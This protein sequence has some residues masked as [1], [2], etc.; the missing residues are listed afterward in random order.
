MW[1]GKRKNSSN[2]SAQLQS[3]SCMD[4]GPKPS[5]CE[6]VDA[7]LRTPPFKGRKEIV[8]PEIEPCSAPP[9]LSEKLRDCKGHEIEDSSECD[10]TGSPVFQ[11]RAKQ[12]FQR[13]LFWLQHRFGSA[14]KRLPSP[15]K[16]DDKST[17]E[18]DSC[19]TMSR[20]SV[21]V[22]EIPV[23][24]ESGMLEKR[25]SQ[26]RNSGK[27]T[28]LQAAITPTSPSQS[29]DTELLKTSSSPLPSPSSRPPGKGGGALSREAILQAELYRARR[30][31]EEQRVK[32][33]K[34]PS[35][36]STHADLAEAP[37]R[38]WKKIQDLPRVL[39]SLT[40]ACEEAEPKP[41][42]L[43][44]ALVKAVARGLPDLL[45]VDEAR[46][47]IA[48][49]SREGGPSL[50]TLDKDGAGREV[51]PAGL[52]GE[53]VA[54][55][56][57]V[58][59]GGGRMVCVPVVKAREGKGRVGA[60]L[61]LNREEEDLG[62]LLGPRRVQAQLE[63]RE[64]VHS[65]IAQHI[66]LLLDGIDSKITLDRGRR[67][68]FGNLSRVV[69]RRKLIQALSRWVAVCSVSEDSD[70]PLESPR[71]MH[72][73]V[74][75]LSLT[76]ALSE[77]ET[78]FQTCDLRTFVGAGER[79]I[80]E[81]LTTA[82]ELEHGWEGDKQSS[83]PDVWII[84][85]NANPPPGSSTME[86]FPFS[87]TALSDPSGYAKS[88]ASG[89]LQLGKGVVCVALANRASMS[90]EVRNT[91]RTLVLAWA[92]W[93]S[94]LQAKAMEEEKAN[95]QELGLRVEEV[96]IDAQALKGE[97]LEAQERFC[98][99]RAQSNENILS[100]EQEIVS[101]NMP[102]A[103]L[104]ATERLLEST[105]DW[106]GLRQQLPVAASLLVGFDRLEYSMRIT[107]SEL[108]HSE[109]L[110]AA[111]VTSDHVVE[112]CSSTKARDSQVL[113]QVL[114]TGVPVKV[115]APHGD[116]LS[117]T[118]NTGRVSP[119]SSSALP[120]PSF[121]VASLAVPLRSVGSPENPIGALLIERSGATVSGF[122]DDDI[123]TI[124][125][126]AGI[127]SGV[128]A[129]LAL[130]ELL[131]QRRP[132]AAAGKHSSR[133]LQVAE[134]LWTSAGN[135][136]AEI[137]ETFEAGTVH[138]L[139][140]VYEDLGQAIDDVRCTV[141]MLDPQQGTLCGSNR[142]VVPVGVGA[143]GTVALTGR[144]MREG[145][146]V[147]YVPILQGK[148]GHDQAATEHY[149]GE[150][151]GAMQVLGVVRVYCASA[152][153]G[154]MEGEQDVKAVQALAQILVSVLQHAQTLQAAFGGM[155]DASAAIQ[156]L[157]TRL[158]AAQDEIFL[159][160]AART[161]AE[162]V[163]S[164]LQRLHAECASGG[165]EPSTALFQA[166]ETA[167]CTTTG[168]DSA[169]FLIVA[170]DEGDE[171]S[172]DKCAGYE[173]TSR[174][175]SAV[176]SGALWTLWPGEACPEERSH[177]RI[178]KDEAAA[179]IYTL[180]LGSSL[181]ICCSPL[182]E[183]PIDNIN[184]FSSSS[185]CSSS[186][187]SGFTA[188]QSWLFGQSKKFER[189]LGSRMSEEK[190]TIMTMPVPRFGD[191]SG[192]VGVLEFV[193]QGRLEGPEEGVL[194]LLAREVGIIWAWTRA[195]EEIS[196]QR[197]EFRELHNTLSDQ[198]NVLKMT[199]VSSQQGGMLANLAF[200]LMAVPDREGAVTAVK[201][202]IQKATMADTVE[203]F[204]Q[205]L[206]PYHAVESGDVLD[207]AL[208]TR[209]HRLECQVTHQ[210]SGATLGSVI[211][212][213]LNLDAD[214]GDT[215]QLMVV[216]TWVML[217]RAL[218]SVEK[219]RALRAMAEGWESSCIS[220]L[221][222]LD[223]VSEE[224]RATYRGL[225]AFLPPAAPHMPL[226]AFDPQENGMQN[227]ASALTEY[228]RFIEESTATLFKL[229]GG[230][231]R[232]HL[233]FAGTQKALN[234]QLKAVGGR[235]K[236]GSP[237]AF[238][239]V[240]GA[241]SSNENEGTRC[242]ASA[243]WR[244]ETSSCGREKEGVIGRYLKLWWSLMSSSD[245]TMLMPGDFVMDVRVASN[246]SSNTILGRRRDGRAILS[247]PIFIPPA[248][249]KVAMS[250]STIMESLVAVLFVERP[251]DHAI[252][253][254]GL[255]SSTSPF[256]KEEISL[257]AQ[258][259][260]Q[261]SQIFSK[262][263]FEVCRKQF[264]ASRR[265]EKALST[266]CV[267]WNHAQRRQAFLEWRSF[268]AQA[269]LAKVCPSGAKSGEYPRHEG[270]SEVLKLCLTCLEAVSSAVEEDETDTIL[271][272]LETAMKANLPGALQTGACSLTLIYP[273]NS[274]RLSSKGTI[275][276][277]AKG[278]QSRAVRKQLQA[279]GLKPDPGYLLV[280]KPVYSLTGKELIGLL[281][282]VVN[283]CCVEEVDGALSV[284]ASFLGGITNLVAALGMA[285]ERCAKA[286]YMME[287]FQAQIR[288]YK[289]AAEAAMQCES[290]ITEASAC[291]LRKCDMAEALLLA[292]HDLP[293]LG[294]VVAE[295]LPH[296]V[297]GVRAI[298][299][300]PPAIT[301]TDA[302]G[303]PEGNRG[304]EAHF[305]ANN[306]ASDRLDAVFVSTLSSAHP[307]I[308]TFCRT[309]MLKRC[310]LSGR[311]VRCTFLA[312]SSRGV[313]KQLSNQHDGQHSDKRKPFFLTVEDPTFKEE[314]EL[315]VIC[316]P[317]VDKK[318]GGVKGLLR[319]DIRTFN[320]TEEDNDGDMNELK[321]AFAY[322]TVLGWASS[323]VG[324]AL[325][326]RRHVETLK[327]RLALEKWTSSRFNHL[328]EL[329]RDFAEKRTICEILQQSSAV[330]GAERLAL[331]VRPA[332][333]GDEKWTGWRTDKD[334]SRALLEF[335][336]YPRPA[337]D[338]K[339]HSIVEYFLAVDANE[340][341]TPK[342]W[343]E[344]REA[345]PHFNS[346]VDL[347]LD[348]E[349]ML[350]VLEIRS[351]EGNGK[352][353]QLIGLC[354]AVW[355]MDVLP[356]GAMEVAGIVGKH[357]SQRLGEILQSHTPVRHGTRSLTSAGLWSIS[358]SSTSFSKSLRVPLNS[359]MET[360]KDLLP[361]LLEMPMQHIRIE[362]F[363]RSISSNVENFFSSSLFTSS[364]VRGNRQFYIDL[365]VQDETG[366][367]TVARDASPSKGIV[368]VSSTPH[369]VLAQAARTKRRQSQVELGQ[370][371]QGRE[372]KIRKDDLVG[373]SVTNV[374]D[375]RMTLTVLPIVAPSGPQGGQLHFRG[376]LRCVVAASEHSTNAAHLVCGDG[377]P[378]IS[379]EEEDVLD[380]IAC[381]IT[382][383]I[384]IFDSV[385]ASKALQ[386][387]YQRAETI[388]GQAQIS[389]QKSQARSDR[390]HDLYRRVWTA[391]CP[392][393]WSPTS[394]LSSEQ[395]IAGETLCGQVARVVQA[396]LQQ[397][398][399][400]F[401]RSMIGECHKARLILTKDGGS[402]AGVDHRLDV[403]DWKEGQRPLVR[404][405]EMIHPGGGSANSGL[406]GRCLRKGQMINVMNP[407]QEEC[408]NIQVDGDETEPTLFVPLLW[409]SQ[410]RAKV[411]GALRVWRCDHD[412]INQATHS[413]NAE[414]GTA[415][416]VS[417]VFTRDD[418]I[419]GETF[420]SHISMALSYAIA[421]EKGGTQ[422]LDW[423]NNERNRGKKA[424]SA[425]SPQCDPP[426]L[427][428]IAPDTFEGASTTTASMK[429]PMGAAAAAAGSTTSENTH[430]QEA[431][432]RDGDFLMRDHSYF[433]ED[434]YVISRTGKA[435][436]LSS[437]MDG[438]NGELHDMHRST[439]RS[440]L[441]AAA[442]VRPLPVCVGFI[443]GMR[444]NENFVGSQSTLPKRNIPSVDAHS[445]SLEQLAKSR[446]SGSMTRH[447]AVSPAPHSIM[448]AKF[449]DFEDGAVEN[450]I[451]EDKASIPL[452]FS[453]TCE[454]QDVQEMK[455]HNQ[456]L[457]KNLKCF[458][459]ESSLPS[460]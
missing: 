34:E 132:G 385:A 209:K 56:C 292:A 8:S 384:T 354:E 345:L 66:D 416:A 68:A 57:T 58:E 404:R 263:L 125:R 318:D 294:R 187:P 288:L 338:E 394:L 94:A 301:A 114:S 99:S 244:M 418:E 229:E 406:L 291:V 69:S 408:Y 217:L 146:H 279:S 5:P 175:V 433:S 186:S 147:L 9:R 377:T 374:A 391:A 93:F 151:T 53:A 331:F 261:V 62:S 119:S 96:E 103:V 236:D 278:A 4:D 448:P 116:A 60:V 28:L 350:G 426:S 64:S 242:R 270:H 162:G 1:K 298:L 2:G 226:C 289:E 397:C 45:C 319:V 218:S 86:N 287:G 400:L 97:N 247:L 206:L 455:E 32:L 152:S 23:A 55:G 276:E 135:S 130:G 454:G 255:I 67:L 202:H 46:L 253:S 353:G 254:N 178:E 360:S 427:L 87:Y 410:A 18:E 210:E 248:A 320:H 88:G 398:G 437:R 161:H 349:E 326:L 293:S 420:A 262:V 14:L 120:S 460:V 109:H 428:S 272:D 25:G 230:R 220:I 160:V 415:I 98:Q 134:R 372:G 179:E 388:L 196:R 118:Q 367:W 458:L 144:P 237:M 422:L 188:D 264:V 267:V 266:F 348:A 173:G 27:R 327:D 95:M 239:Q 322:D 181:N 52:V 48:V 101:G 50:W 401:Y 243:S 61:Q 223:L 137:E 364:R 321:T 256:T 172:A 207:V 297:S 17:G 212:E 166:I 371:Q 63:K 36:G 268:Y 303:K 413:K 317:V 143:V 325:S 138:V 271:S 436:P 313:K 378:L 421:L 37:G 296:L 412:S 176:S 108:G 323:V 356:C 312:L 355:R 259:S 451:L 174:S 85:C 339:Y 219:G 290:L 361:M 251:Q 81:M 419:M 311:P 51:P 54:S 310:F 403:Y 446:R 59:A 246:P 409:P 180:R 424:F 44:A 351:C 273:R 115:F 20:S 149:K 238:W 193:K 227:Q 40:A 389:I 308:E 77:L 113:Q 431:A 155:Q 435:T 107:A 411:M 74:Q 167:V 453:P 7:R 304:T 192:I 240:A 136:L 432:R 456:I 142:E 283:D 222:I 445:R 299:Y 274:K 358:E 452:H 305:M 156:S 197:L 275:K 19:G 441:P 233:R 343:G 450:P 440:Y 171:K 13:R 425:L 232:V 15:A 199:Q 177:R 73:A 434:N 26:H 393:W 365:F 285:K 204:V 21:L 333:D 141:F 459:S 41:D 157:Q 307:F 123:E 195:K 124:S 352:K 302:I 76:Y 168:A 341:C 281:E 200:D 392:L 284:L 89:K 344:H 82:P 83:T 449:G 369:G 359:D 201:D 402:R 228:V 224:L 405:H 342:I 269:S 102:G 235:R 375:T 24:T 430:G 111:G 126:F 337:G 153:K 12:P 139:I 122:Q 11:R 31:L 347:P 334:M 79:T 128:M 309:E 182:Q 150:G 208:F 362:D 231:G 194:S 129:R 457:S 252:N 169:A 225:S 390:L 78:A 370:H 70:S 442:A 198:T 396:A 164:A 407:T 381:V 39:A 148:P 163:L 315:I 140:G 379:K 6:E 205:D 30:Q 373:L 258:W 42:V 335:K 260:S 10:L 329:N 245:S 112:I 383:S 380:T 387:L 417:P 38:L 80:R 165:S 300:V 145:S 286:A 444:N 257:A 357:V 366:L 340:G 121:A 214:L 154:S 203:V 105:W 363:I 314:H 346:E 16:L 423:E 386:H 414:K 277:A 324:R 131:V 3:D 399:H 133:L 216:R 211:M 33:K 295:H 191:K 368:R 47:F 185:T 280:S 170:E 49:P 328:A 127:V 447:S 189:N 395:L 376:L 382:G 215:I 100:V 106:E 221:G 438:M 213:G 336:T 190:V 90:T 330:L 72:D 75:T 249:K 91:V 71:S 316:E 332:Q 92:A 84:L 241:G 65:L 282:V 29:E 117:S 43:R 306:E 439:R 159:E 184:P 158:G 234:L 429:V 265:Q 250:T 443:D 110:H 104:E 22:D 35:G 183:S